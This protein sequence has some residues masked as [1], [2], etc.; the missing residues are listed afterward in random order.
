MKILIRFIAISCLLT[1]S[2]ILAS[3]GGVAS[4]DDPRQNIASQFT[5]DDHLHPSWHWSQPGITSILTLDA[6]SPDELVWSIREKNR[7][8]YR[9]SSIHSLQRQPRLLRAGPDGILEVRF[10]P[11]GKSILI[12]EEA[13]T[14]GHSLII[15]FHQ[16]SFTGAWSSYPLNLTPPSKQ[17]YQK[18]DDGSQ[19]PLLNRPKATIQILRLDERSVIYEIDKKT[20]SKAF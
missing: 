13:P 11:S 16:D 17:K 7:G 12:Q 20:Y 10:S 9:R 15:L 14:T 6:R 19:V 8:S 3:C 5:L 2:I 1:I 4:I 18:L